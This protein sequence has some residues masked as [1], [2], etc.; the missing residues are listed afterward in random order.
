MRFLLILMFNEI[1]KTAHNPFHSEC[2]CQNYKNRNIF[3][4]SEGI[5]ILSI[6]FE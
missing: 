3:I 4:Y 2:V 5:F 6:K 1:N